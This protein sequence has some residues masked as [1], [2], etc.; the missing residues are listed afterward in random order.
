MQCKK[1]YPN[2]ERHI[3]AHITLRVINR[4]SLQENITTL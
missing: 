4:G 1:D 2:Q 3:K